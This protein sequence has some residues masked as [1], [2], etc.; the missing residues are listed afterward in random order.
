MKKRVL[1]AFLLFALFCNLG[2]SAQGNYYNGAN[3]SSEEYTRGVLNLFP[4]PSVNYATIVL[5]YIPVNRINIDLV[6]FNGNLLRRFAF[7]PGSQQMSIDVSDLE[8]GFYILRVR[9]RNSLVDI[10]KLVKN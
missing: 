3:R 8:R 10:L 1:V 9:E 4:N 7:S 6:D 2:V 5:N